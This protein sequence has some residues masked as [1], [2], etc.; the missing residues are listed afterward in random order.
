MFAAPGRIV[1]NL[2]MIARL[3]RSGVNTFPGDIKAA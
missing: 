1:A 2:P 3:L